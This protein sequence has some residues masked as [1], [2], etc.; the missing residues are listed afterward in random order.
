MTAHASCV[1]VVEDDDAIRT[2]VR[3]L[4]EDEGYAVE[5]A[6]D[7]VA[8]LAALRASPDRM[9]VLL[10]LLMP[11]MDGL[12]MLRTLADNAG[13]ATRHAYIMIAAKPIPPPE[14]ADL[15]GRLGAPYLHKPFAI[16]DLLAVVADAA[17][18]LG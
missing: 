5:E 6:T 8:A 7:G 15:L 14:V 12:T 4:L 11:G 17:G 1:L 10:D 2:A 13:L 16:D 9:V 3:M 18:R